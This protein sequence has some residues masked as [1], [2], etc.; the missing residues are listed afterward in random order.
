[1]VFVFCRDERGIGC[2]VVGSIMTIA[3]GAG[4]GFYVNLL[5][6]YREH[7]GD[8]VSKRVDAL[9]VRPD[10]EFIIL[11]MGNGARRADRAM[12]GVGFEIGAFDFV[13]GLCTGFFDRF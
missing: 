11:I 7:P 2:A 6:I 4:Y 8:G 5:G 12:H 9:R 13:C 3:S 10:S 1:M